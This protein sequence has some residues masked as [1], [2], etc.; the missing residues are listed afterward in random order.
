[1]SPDNLRRLLDAGVENAAQEL[2]WLREESD[3]PTWLAEAIARRCAHEPLAYI[4]GWQEFHGLRFDLTPDVLIPRPE[5]EGIIDL[6]LARNSEQPLRR[7]VDVGTGSACIAVTLAAKT[8]VAEVLAIDLSEAAL[9]VARRNAVRHGVEARVTFAQGDLLA[10]AQAWVG[11]VDLIAANLPYVAEGEADSLQPEVLQ[12]PREALVAGPGGLELI[13]R[14]VP[15]AWPLL[16]PGGLLILE[17]GINQAAEVADV[18]REAPCASLT[19]HADLAGIPRIV[20]ASRP[21]PPSP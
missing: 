10:P 2:R 14:L 18:L 13:R 21:N 1:M 9:V 7:V 19:T 15:Q 11:T 8:S 3:D 12:E 20:S 17:V 5:T 4:V 16:R 6:A